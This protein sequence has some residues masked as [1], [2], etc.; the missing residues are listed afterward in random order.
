VPDILYTERRSQELSEH[1]GD[2][3][4][5]VWRWKLAL[6]A[7]IATAGLLGAA[8]VGPVRAELIPYLSCSTSA[9]CLEWD[10]TSSGSAFKGVSTK[11]SAV[12]GQT[13]FKSAGKTAGKSGVLGEDVSTSGTLDSGVS[14]VSVNGTGVTGTSTS[15]NG[16]AGF[17][18][19]G[20]ASGVYGQNSASSGFGIAGRNTSATHNAGGAAILADGS[21]ASDAL[22]AFANGAN[23][24]SVYAF[25]QSGTSLFANQG[26]S[27]AAPELYLQDTS[28]SFNKI[29]QAV[30]P[31][32]DVLD[33]QSGQSSLNGQFT[34]TSNPTAGGAERI[35]NQA[36]NLN[37]ALDIVGGDHVNDFPATIMMSAFDS[38]GTALMQ[39]NNNGDL[40][41]YGTLIQGLDCSAG[42]LDGKRRVRSVSGYAALESEPTIEDNGEQTLVNGVARVSLD[43]KFANVIDAS[44]PYIVTVTPE[45]DC[46]GLYVTGRSIHGFVVRE[47]RGGT[48]NVGFGYRIVANQ[49]GT[50]A[51]RLPMSDVRR[52]RRQPSRS[53]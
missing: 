9:P 49:Y 43:P 45:G 35:I 24:T 28:S 34:V 31:S 30:G 12:D 39:L 27:D 40:L 4:M 32:G 10:N 53:K 25:S 17:T 48:S 5:N 44:R 7:S 46:N 15:L 13:K 26:P 11:G 21:T 37:D 20:G 52:M 18:S 23:S 6:A 50:N 42:C 16:V 33:V 51:T 19:G 8:F 47:L 41:I 1:W 38:S 14:G 3:I 29:I 2:S 36:G 22:H